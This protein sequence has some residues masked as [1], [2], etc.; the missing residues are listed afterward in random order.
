VELV[1]AREMAAGLDQI[2]GARLLLPAYWT[3]ASCLA[4]LLRIL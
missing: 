1:D 4:P 3:T 2:S